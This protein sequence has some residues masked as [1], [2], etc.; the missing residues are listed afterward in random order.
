MHKCLKLNYRNCPSDS[1]KTLEISQDGIVEKEN[2]VETNIVL[3]SYIK[4]I[5]Y[6]YSPT[7][8]RNL[9]V[10]KLVLKS[11]KFFFIHNEFYNKKTYSMEYQNNEYIDFSRCLQQ[12]VTLNST[13]C[14]FAG[15]HL[16]QFILF[17]L[18][19]VLVIGFLLIYM[20]TLD[21][22]LQ[23]SLHAV[24]IAGLL[25]VNYKHQ[26]G[27]FPRIIVSSIPDRVLPKH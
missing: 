14:Q 13:I 23:M 10:T 21:S 1:L 4:Y 12:N 27:I 7:A 9:Y 26:R 6:Y 20:L 25:Y 19:E 17:L 2:G 22:T 3:F 5:Y 8:H 11:G 18:L 24:I 15:R 16:F